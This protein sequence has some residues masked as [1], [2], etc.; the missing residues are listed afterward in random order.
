MNRFFGMM[1]WK[2][3]EISKTFKDDLGL[4]IRVEAGKN[5]WTIL[6]ADSSTEYK[7]VE[8]TAENNFQSALAVLR[9]KF[10]VTEIDNTNVGCIGEC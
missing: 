4:R 3:V 6:Y 1:P 8:D 9:S 10:N 7:D 5:G 2:L